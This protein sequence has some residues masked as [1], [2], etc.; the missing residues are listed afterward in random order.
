MKYTSSEANKLLK[1]L[2]QEHDHLLMME[3][4]SCQF[5]AALG[6]DVESVRPEYDYAKTQEALAE[7]LY[8]TRQTVSNYENGRSRPDLDMLLKIAQVLETDVNTVIY[9]PAIAPSKRNS[10]RWLAISAGLFV[11]VVALYAAIEFMLPKDVFGYQHSVRLIMRLTLL[12]TVM[13]IFGWVLIHLLSIFCNL[14]QLRSKKIKALRVFVL[15]LLG[16]LIAIPIPLVIFHGIA[17]YRSF[18]YHNVS[19]SFPYIPVYTQAYMVIHLAIF[20]MPFLYSI[21]GGI[22]WVLG[23]PCT[24]EK[25]AN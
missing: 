13:F 19:M 1:Q 15:M 20:K 4:Q 5:N 10:Y 2:N 25:T 22:F 7:A 23:L 17:G 21:L 8:V 11:A 3:S 9:G 14:Q 24:T 12:P 16:L 6:E 18:A